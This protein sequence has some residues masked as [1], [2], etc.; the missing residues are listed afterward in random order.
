MIYTEL[1]LLITPN[2]QMRELR[3]WFNYF[4]RV[5]YWPN[6]MAKTQVQ[7]IWGDFTTLI[8][9]ITVLI[10]EML[11]SRWGIMNDSG[12]A[13]S[14]TSTLP[15]CPPPNALVLTWTCAIS[16]VFIVSLTRNLWTGENR[17][18]LGRY[19]HYGRLVFFRLSQWLW[20]KE[21]Q[22]LSC[23]K[24]LFCYFAAIVETTHLK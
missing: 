20:C 24:F 4:P 11:T 15:F 3:L 17:Y 23:Q 14:S 13:G 16:R 5:N 19:G 9:G 1:I 18:L 8:Y 10:P 21:H 7:V 2:S 22:N 6:S 12:S